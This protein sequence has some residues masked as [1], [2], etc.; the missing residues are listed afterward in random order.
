MRELI[1]VTNAA[2]LAAVAQASAGNPRWNPG[3]AASRLPEGWGEFA[4]LHC[5]CLAALQAGRRVEAYEKAV[6]ALQ[7]FIRVRGPGPGRLETGAGAAI[8]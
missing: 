5:A 3:N 1:A 8:V 7:P 4:A 2:A 6:A